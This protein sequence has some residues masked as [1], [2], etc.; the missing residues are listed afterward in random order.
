MRHKILLGFGILLFLVFIGTISSTITDI[1]PDNDAWLSSSNASFTFT[2]SNNTNA[3]CSLV[4]NDQVQT[5]FQANT[6]N[7]LTRTLLEGEH[8]WYANCTQDEQSESFAQRTLYLD[9]TAPTIEIIS[10]TNNSNHTEINNVSF[11]PSDNLALNISCELNLNNSIQSLIVSNNTLTNALINPAIGSNDF[12][13]NCQ[14][15]AGNNVSS[16]TRTFYL[17]NETPDL[18]VVDDFAFNVTLDKQSYNIGES[19]LMQINAYNGSNVT[20]EIGYLS[21]SWF[22]AEFDDLVYL[23]EEYPL[24]DSM[25]YTNITGTYLIRAEM[26]SVNGTETYWTNFTVNNNIVIVVDGDL[27]IDEGEKTELEVSVTGGIAPYT[28]KWILDDGTIKNQKNI[29]FTYNNPGDYNQLLSVTDSVGNV[30]NLSV[31]LNVRELF[32]VDIYVQ[33]VASGNK[34]SSAIVKLNGVSKTTNN[35]GLASYWISKGYYDLT[36]S[37]S[38]Y[39][40]YLEDDY[41]VSDNETETILLNKV[42]VSDPVISMQSPKEGA[43]IEGTELNVSFSV[44]DEADYVVCDVFVSEEN[45][46]FIKKKTI[47]V[48]STAI[49]TVSIKNLDFGAHSLKVECEDLKGNVGDSS[50]ISF[51]LENVSSVLSSKIDSTLVDDLYSILD[52]IPQ[53]N[54]HEKQVIE[55]LEIEKNIQLAIKTVERGLRDL[56]NVDY[57]KDLSDAERKLKEKE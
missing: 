9:L 20:L 8:S 44:S 21:G 23:S 10:P 54:M 30:K 39:D 25:P 24:I 52:S 15:L 16:E 29:N 33:D 5:T 2:L 22:V 1:G 56:A 7:I 32:K 34:I 18:V 11:R 53:K 51:V 41:R 57:R 40:Y 6:T 27:N 55:A 48:T 26:D 46:W 31:D 42:D 37:H 35:L 19:S 13:I 45:S 43:V 12:N 49:Q 28:Y 47:E 14:D 50:I 36:V 17:I 3:T 4:I 38:N